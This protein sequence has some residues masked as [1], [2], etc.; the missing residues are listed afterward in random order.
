MSH[1]QPRGALREESGF[2]PDRVLEEDCLALRGFARAISQMSL[3]AA[4]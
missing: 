3:M 2:V 4:R 1:V